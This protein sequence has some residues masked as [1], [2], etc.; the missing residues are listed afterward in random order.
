[1]Q[2]ARFHP[3]MAGHQIVL[4]SNLEETTQHGSEGFPAALYETVFRSKMLRY[5]PLH[6]HKELQLCLILTGRVRFSIN[7]K[8]VEAGAGDVIF[9]N[10]Q[11]IHSATSISNDEEEA[12]YC[13]INFAYEMVG[14]FH[15][16]LMERNFVLP[17]LRNEQNDFLLISEKSEE[18]LL[19]EISSKM[20]HI[21]KLFKE[22]EPERYFD[23][24]SEL[25]LIW[26][27]LVRWLHKTEDQP[28]TRRP[29]DY[30]TS[31]KVISYIEKNLGEK[32]TLDLIAKEVCLSKWECS[33]RFKRIAG[34]SVWSYLISARMAKA[35]ELLLY[36][37]KSVERI[38][39]EV[40]FPN[41]NLFIRQFKKEFRTTPGQFRKN[42]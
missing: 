37:R 9:I 14:G 21:R 12:S 25:V 18:G 30:E 11:V 6:W 40:G 17:F 31:R 1:M 32:L 39:F 33:R 34:E 4:K 38:G 24:F 35:V 27:E 3:H 13:C 10:S 2:T 26:K 7:Q 28:S 8:E 15:G 16:S 42:H 29:E 5:V 41:V 23:I 19:E 36:S 20:L 22:T